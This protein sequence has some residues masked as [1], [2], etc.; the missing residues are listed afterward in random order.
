MNISPGLRPLCVF[1]A[2]LALLLAAQPS[3]VDAQGKKA[4]AQRVHVVPH[5]A[6]KPQEAM[7]AWTV[8]TSV[9]PST[10]M[11]GCS[12]ATVDAAGP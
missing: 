1:A 5:Q 9:E 12:A 4:K 11:S 2:L 6:P 8:G 10:T 7:N 3:S